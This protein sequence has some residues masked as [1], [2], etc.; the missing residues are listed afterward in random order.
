MKE[1][2]TS[3]GSAK[4]AIDQ[5]AAMG[6]IV[7]PTVSE[8]LKDPKTSVRL[9]AA[10]ILTRLG[11]AASAAVPPLIET[12]NDKEETV[13][14]QAAKAL[15]VMNSPEAKNPLRLYYLKELIRPYLKTLHITI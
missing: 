6:P 3:T 4:N 12:L 14:R 15:E 2:R 1:I 13:R 11:P 10:Q 5:L 8:A 9:A 7:V